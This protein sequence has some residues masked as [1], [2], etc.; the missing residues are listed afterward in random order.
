LNGFVRPQ[1][2]LNEAMHGI[3]ASAVRQHPGHVGTTIEQRAVDGLG[4][5]VIALACRL[6]TLV[7]LLVFFPATTFAFAQFTTTMVPLLAWFADHGCRS[8]L[9]S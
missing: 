7:D 9:R 6:E 1:D 2:L 4:Q 3:F 5:S 8:T